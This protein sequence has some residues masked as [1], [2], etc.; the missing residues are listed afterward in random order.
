MQVVI[1]Y[2]GQGYSDY[3]STFSIKGNLNLLE[4][5]QTLVDRNLLLLRDTGSSTRLSKCMLNRRHRSWVQSVCEYVSIPSRLTSDG[6]GLWSTH[7]S[8]ATTL[9]ILRLLSSTSTACCR[10]CTSRC[11]CG[12]TCSCARCRYCCGTTPSG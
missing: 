12:T 4:V 5:D 9:A 11:R 1:V 10:S 3:F 6:T 7:P 2:D 8:L